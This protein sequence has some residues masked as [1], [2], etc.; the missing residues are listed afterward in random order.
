MPLSLRALPREYVLGKLFKLPGA[1]SCEPIYEKR[2]GGKIVVYVPGEMNH[3]VHAC[4]IYRE[5]KKRIWLFNPEDGSFTLDD[6]LE[7]GEAAYHTKNGNQLR[8]R[9]ALLETVSKMGE[10]SLRWASNQKVKSSVE[11]PKCKADALAFGLNS[12]FALMK[13]EGSCGQRRKLW[14]CRLPLEKGGEGV[15]VDGDAGV[16]G[17]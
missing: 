14:L 6:K 10:I 15:D 12:L 4:S 9:Y 7:V 3:F 1:A 17:D 11:V 16:A 8:P 2:A 5:A 13:E